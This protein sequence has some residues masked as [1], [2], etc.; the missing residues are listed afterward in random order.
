MTEHQVLFCPFCR[1]SFEGTARCPDHDLA[2][3]G[4]EKLG[5]DPFDPENMPEVID[6]TPLATLD[7]VFGRGYVAAGA[8]LNVL[9]FACDL[10]RA[11]AH[12]PGLSTRELCLNLPSLWTLGLVSFTLL[13]ILRRRRTPK[14]MRS[15][16]LLVPLL[17][18][19]SPATLA[20]A[21]HRLDQGVI[22]WA[23]GQRLV[24]AQ[25]G[26]AVYVVGLASCLIFAGGFRLGVLPKNLRSRLAEG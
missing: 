10:V 22:V 16:R 7:P 19:I 14:A 24:H 15:V 2:L 21:F 9:A 20:W 17:A 26:S 25:P 13:F 11:Q 6:E 8:L 23:T 5:P 18:L 4:F 1:E 3:V 12:T